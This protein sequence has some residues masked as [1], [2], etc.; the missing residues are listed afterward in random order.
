MA[1]APERVACLVL[2]AGRSERFGGDKLATVFD[3]RPLLHHSLGT[4]NRFAWAAKLAVTRSAEIGV[5]APGFVRIEVG[6]PGAPQ[7]HSLR[8]GLARVPTTGIDAVLVALGDMPLVSPGHIARLLD[9]FDPADPRCVVASVAGERRSPPAL[10][11]I[12]LL[13]ELMALTGDRGAGTF[14]R[15]ALVVA[16][17]PK[18]LADI[19]SPEDLL[20][21]ESKT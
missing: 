16:A 17:P 14:L 3:G 7:S 20:R 21:L 1:V 18:E 6:T 19:D 11:A 2:A 9:R 15:N 13:P 10:F 8:H 5:E 12:A 4:L